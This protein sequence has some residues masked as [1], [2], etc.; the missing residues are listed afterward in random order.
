MRTGESP[1]GHQAPLAHHQAWA[2]L[3][4]TCT[5][6]RREGSCR[7]GLVPETRGRAA[8]RACLGACPRPRRPSQRTRPDPEF[9]RVFSCS[10]LRLS[11]FRFIFC[12]IFV[13]LKTPASHPPQRPSDRPVERSTGVSCPG[14]AWPARSPLTRCWWQ[15]CLPQEGCGS[16]APSPHRKSSGRASSRVVYGAESCS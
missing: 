7:E 11:S 16:S 10:A 3:P 8:S 5:A 4:R 2:P 14:A 9:S 15:Q 6:V 12:S 1:R 13:A